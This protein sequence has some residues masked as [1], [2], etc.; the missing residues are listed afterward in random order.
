RLSRQHDPL[1]LQGQGRARR[2]GLTVRVGLEEGDLQ[3]LAVRADLRLEAQGA[4]LRVDDA[5]SERAVGLALQRELPV[6]TVQHAGERARL[7]L[8]ERDDHA[9]LRLLERTG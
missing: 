1:P 9:R 7:R 6:R 2:Y 8:C 3:V 4:L 5:E